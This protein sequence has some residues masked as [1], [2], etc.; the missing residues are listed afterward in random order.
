MGY[1]I[2]RCKKCN[3]PLHIHKY[4]R[5]FIIKN[6]CSCL[7]E[8]DIKELISDGQGYQFKYIVFED[9]NEIDKF[10][11]TIGDDWVSETDYQEMIKAMEIYNRDFR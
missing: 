9:L 1:L 5:G 8:L 10:I 4:K 3:H 6:K 2:K 7:T 11:N